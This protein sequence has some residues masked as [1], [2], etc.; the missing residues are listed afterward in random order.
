M[1]LRVYAGF[2]G[3]SQ[4]GGSS[5][6]VRS[7]DAGKGFQMGGDPPKLIGYRYGY[8]PWGPLVAEPAWLAPCMPTSRAWP[9]TRMP[10]SRR[11][12]CGAMMQASPGPA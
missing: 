1:A 9:R 8:E 10:H 3:P 12:Q 2:D 4:L 5:G 6:I 7:D 11:L